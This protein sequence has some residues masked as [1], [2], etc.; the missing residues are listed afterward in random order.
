M[1]RGASSPFSHGGRRL[2]P[3]LSLL[4][5]LSKGMRGTSGIM[6]PVMGMHESAADSLPNSPWDKE[7]DSMAWL[8]GGWLNAAHEIVDRHAR[9]RLGNR[10]ALV[11]VGR[12]GE[13][14]RYTFRQIK[15]LSDRFANVLDSL[16]VVRGDTVLI[17]LDRIP[18][19]YFAYLGALKSGA[20]AGFLSPDL[21]PEQVQDRMAVTAA[22][23]LVTQPGLRRRMGGIVYELFDLQHIVIVNK[24]G[25]DPGPPD[26]A[27]LVYEEEMSKAPAEYRTAR[28]SQLDDATVHFT[29]GVS[30]KAKVVLHRHQAVVQHYA[31]GRTVL[32]RREDD[33]YWCTA[34]PDHLAGAAYGIAA[35]WSN[36]VTQLVYE[37]P[38]DSDTPLELIRDHGVTV[39][40]TAPSAL[41]DLTH[42]EPV[43]AALRHVVSTGEPLDAELASL[44]QRVLGVPI[45][46]SYME[47]ETGAIVCANSPGS[48]PAPGSI[49]APV[50]GIEMAVLSP[51]FEPLAP[52]VEGRLAIRPGWPSMFARYW[53]DS[54]L[55]ND[56]FR[57]GWYLTDDRAVADLDG[58]FRLAGRAKD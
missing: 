42:T 25:R 55:Y 20:V 46:D 49:G 48:E 19:L 51:G 58:R 27:D 5:S 34:P 14:E 44:G 57:R 39:M 4:K 43:G 23:I 8:P 7:Y 50:P 2:E 1:G 32:D 10:T 28:T 54:R 47:T 24:N 35:P 37:G 12:G 16:G 33:V 13:V 6:G 31:T 41:R 17:Y 45:H 29:A 52:G 30:G 26:I 53:E 21:G 56:R 38:L 3:A 36:G 22:K 9:G 18:E 15:A 11:W 40:F